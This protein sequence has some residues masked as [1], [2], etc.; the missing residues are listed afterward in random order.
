MNMFLEMA[1]CY[2][3]LRDYPQA[4]QMYEKAKKYD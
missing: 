2:R 1:L 4:A 3:E